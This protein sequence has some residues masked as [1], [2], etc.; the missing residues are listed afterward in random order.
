MVAA[1]RQRHANTVKTIATSGA[2]HHRLRFHPAGDPPGSNRARSP[3]IEDLRAYGLHP[4]ENKLIGEND[5]MNPENAAQGAH[6]QP[7]RGSSSAFP[8]KI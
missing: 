7:R 1:G 2:I 4:R 5:S 8:D 3:T 6:A